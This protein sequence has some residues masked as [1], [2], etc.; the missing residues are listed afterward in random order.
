[1]DY[2]ELFCTL[3]PLTS[4][5]NFSVLN[6]AFLVGR[7]GVEPTTPAKGADLQSAAFADSLPTHMVHRA[8]VEPAVPEG[9]VSEAGVYSSSTTCAYL[10]YRARL[11]LA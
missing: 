3:F 5:K 9:P 10:V 4:E 11:E 1:M 8:G 7:V 2:L 6:M